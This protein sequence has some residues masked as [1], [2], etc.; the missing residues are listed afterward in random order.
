VYIAQ[1]HA[2]H[3]ESRNNKFASKPLTSVPGMHYIEPVRVKELSYIISQ[4]EKH[5][6][7]PTLRLWLADTDLAQL[8]RG[9]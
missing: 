6:T 5:E 2:Q 3:L 7:V 4:D 1:G 9:V 8:W